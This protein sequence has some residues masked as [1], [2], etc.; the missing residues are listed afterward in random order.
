MKH[1]IKVGLVGFGKAGNAVA[2]VLNDDTRFELCWVA[3]RSVNGIQQAA[4]E[5]NVPFVS[6]ERQSFVELLDEMPVDALVD[7]SSPLGICN[8][9][10]EVRKRG[11]TLVSA[12]SNYS[13]SDLD[14]A[15]IIAENT[16]VLCSPNITLGINFLIVA[17]KLLRK[18]APFADVEILEQHF[19]EKP[20]VSGTARK[21]A[22][23]LDV[24]SEQITS[25]RLGG[26]VG[27]H[28]VIFGFPH[29][30]VRLTHESIRR[31]AF[32]T[33]VAF[34]LSQLANFSNGFYTFED[35]LM[36]LAR[37]E[38]QGGPLS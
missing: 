1:K 36:R 26:I 16:R 31:E 19:R 28:E 17:A 8:Y 30:T 23:V 20:D 33:G 27:H 11:I 25:L 6:T 13:R 7:F 12:I 34:A 32:G 24:D 10:E 29:Q 15:R 5:W 38:L 4:T 37:S 35:I 22:E 21:I 3:R 18:I 9:G 14:Y 2:K